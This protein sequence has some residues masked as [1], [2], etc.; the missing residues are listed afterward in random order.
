MLFEAF[1]EN[2]NNHAKDPAFLIS[3]GDRSIP[4]S[5]REFTDDINLVVYGIRQRCPGAVIGILGENSYEWMVSHAAI[6]FSGATVLPLD[7]NL[8][9]EEIAG[10]LEKTGSKVLVFSALYAEKAAAVEKLLPSVVVS[11]FGSFEADAFLAQS[12]REVEKCGFSVFDAE[13]PDAT[14]TSMIVFTSGTT[15]EP[16]GVELT[17]EGL[18]VFSVYSNERLSY[19]RGSRSLMLLPLLHI[20]GI[21]VTYAMLA[22]G[23]ALGVCPDYRRIFDAIVRFKAEFL[24]LVPALADIL[25]AKIEQRGRSVEDAL[26]FNIEWI[27]TGGAPISLRT[28][29]RLEALGVKM[30][31]AYGLTETTAVY[32][33]S[34]LNG[35]TPAGSAGRAC[36]FPG[37][38]TRVSSGGELM[39]RGPGVMKGYFR[40]KS[41][42]DEVKDVDGWFRTGDSGTID[43]DGIVYVHGRISRTI[44]LSSGKKIAPE[45]LESKISMYPGIREVMVS[46]DGQTRDI[47]AEVYADIPEGGVHS[48]IQSMNLSLPV[49]M[50]VKRV[51]VRNKPFP[52]TASG[53]IELPRKRLMKPSGVSPMFWWSFGVGLLTIA[54]F[55]AELALSRLVADNPGASGF[56]RCVCSL[57]ESLGD[58]MSVVLALMLMFC[59]WKFLRRR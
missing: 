1:K 15:S 18:E 36:D 17:L 31:C 7:V 41:R 13:A 32:S 39:I 43:D 22:Q 49:Y 54:A 28:R 33:M 8:S 44:V 37:V 50:R 27:C 14:R 56:V 12:R 11:G 3:A 9:P 47:V 42:T 45:E 55:A 5:W 53:K 20:F 21:S 52:R 58:M 59:A 16:R 35:V 2:R 48:I 30:L 4:I 6:V 25:A 26:G 38:E 19:R 23:V 10:R 57:S 40:E 29:K 34:D 51:V 24:F 46:G